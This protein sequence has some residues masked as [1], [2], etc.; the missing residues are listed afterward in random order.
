MQINATF[1]IQLINFAITY[2][3]LNKFMFKPVLSFLQNKKAKE[4]S[5]QEKLCLSEKILLEME[6]DKQNSL[7]EFQENMVE[8]YEFVSPAKCKVP[9]EISY[10]VDKEETKKLTEK[11]KDILVER[12]PHVD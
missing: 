10:K 2:W 3:F 8:K 6:K 7:E 5:F 12:V 11:V 1:F 4:K 9:P